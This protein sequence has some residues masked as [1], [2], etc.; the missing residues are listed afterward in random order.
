MREITLRQYQ[1]DAVEALREGVR[2][3]HRSQ[4]LCAPTGAGK[5]LVAA[6]L[7]DEARKKNTKVAFV[8]DRVSLVDQTSAVL[9]DYGIAHGVIQANHWRRQ[10][11]EPIQICSAQTLEKRG[12]FPDLKMLVVDEAHCMRKATG[13]LIQSKSDLLVFG[14]TATP[15]AKGMAELY[16]RVVNVTTTNRLIED[17]FLV[18]IRAYAAKAVDMRGAKVVAGEWTDSEIEER[19]REIVGDIVN[20]WIDKTKKHFGGPA[21]TIVFAASVGHGEEL[22]RQFN[23]AGYNFQQ[24]SYLDTNDERRRELIEEFRKKDSAIDGLVA[25]EILTKGFDVPDVLVGISARPYRK[26]LSSHVQQL[27][28]VMR[29]CEG[30][31]F[32]LW[33]DHSGNYLRFRQDAEDLFAN[34]VSELEAK[35]RDAEARKEPTEKE[36]AEIRCV[37]GYV[38]PPS[39]RVC[40]A[41][42]KE[43]ER[44]AMVETVSGVMVAVNHDGKP[45][46]DAFQNRD[47]VW[48]QIIGYALM[49]RPG[50]PVAARKLALAQFR[51]IYGR[52][53]AEE[54]RPDIADVPT[55]TV[56]NRI[57]SNLIRYANRRQGGRA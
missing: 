55:L 4:V 5:T 26:S 12:F 39:A 34:G 9:D 41:C 29:P 23:D 21:K 27:G 1:I 57:R 56:V 33:L 48:R 24:I 43:R 16:S 3:G 18:P 14:L 13:A 40:P 50:D 28:R 11:W 47:A 36:R 20:E 49:R 54:Y 30:K 45:L 17:K 46:P 7:M 31:E 6:H 38:L 8:V 37:C 42:G 52:F 2:S 25:C 15:F 32:A 22:C 53:P 44:R 35:S 51:A 19:G 10:H